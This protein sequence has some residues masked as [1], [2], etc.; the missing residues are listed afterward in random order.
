VPVGTYIDSIRG[1]ESSGPRT[2]VR[3]FQIVVA[4]PQG[5]HTTGTEIP[6]T[7]SLSQNYPNPFNPVTNIRFGLPKASVVSLKVYDILGREVAELVKN[8]NLKAGSYL[9]DFDAS[10]LPSGIYCYK[11]SAGDFSDVKKMVL[12]K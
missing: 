5:I 9:F 1:T 3:T 8:E 12:V 10:N 7:Y 4:L 2:H 11:F 6:K